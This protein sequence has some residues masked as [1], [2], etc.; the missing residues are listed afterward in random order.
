MTVSHWAAM[1]A[2]TWTLRELAAEVADVLRGYEAAP[3]GQVRAVPDERAIR[4][5]ASLGLLDP[6]AAMRGRTALYGRRHL[7]QLVAIKRLQAVGRSLAEVQAILPGL[8]D[9]SL[10]RASGVA[11]P[12][13]GPPSGA[14]ADFWRR[15]PAQAGPPT[16]QPIARAAGRAPTEPPTVA[17]AG[18]AA[19]VVL[20]LA[21][22]CHDPR[23][24]GAG[25]DRGRRRR[26]PPGRAGAGRR[27][28]PAAAPRWM[29]TRRTRA[30][31]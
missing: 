26:R 6:P 7:A 24:P 2:P 14:R 10:E 18:F 22:G 4:Y 29:T 31:P 12:R 13:R 15:E 5:Y 30:Q 20:E 1:D 16:A 21:P 17:A 23:G 3:N 19:R 11:V 25:A 8:D 28:P 27:A 9:A